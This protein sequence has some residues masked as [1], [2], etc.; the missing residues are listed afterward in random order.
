VKQK[1]NKR[2]KKKSH[3]NQVKIH[4]SFEQDTNFLDTPKYK[5]HISM[6]LRGQNQ[7]RHLHSQK[8]VF[9]ND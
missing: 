3:K 8:V 5:C 7:L 6:K 4:Q 1:E 2:R 9:K